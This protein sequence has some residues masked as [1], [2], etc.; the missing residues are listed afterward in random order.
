MQWKMFIKSSFSLKNISL[1]YTITQFLAYFLHLPCL[2]YYKYLKD[3]YL[4][5]FYSASAVV[6]T[7]AV[8]FLSAVLHDQ[9]MKPGLYI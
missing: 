8:Y 9:E 6:C 4:N 3:L 5:L 7:S 2:S 1:F